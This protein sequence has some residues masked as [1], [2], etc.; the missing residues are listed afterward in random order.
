MMVSRVLLISLSSYV[1]ISISWC[2]VRSCDG[3]LHAY[4]LLYV[5]A[6]L[7]R[8]RCDKHFGKVLLTCA[9]DMPKKIEAA[10]LL[11]KSVR[12]L[13]TVVENGICNP[14]SGFETFSNIDSM[15]NCSKTL[16]FFLS[17]SKS[18]S[19]RNGHKRT[20]PLRHQ[21]K[22]FGG[23]A[24]V[25]VPPAGEGRQ[26]GRGMERVAEAPRIE[27]LWKSQAINWIY[28]ECMVIE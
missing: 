6:W 4:I 7:W 17:L 21:C 1:K 24:G 23:H 10:P 8:R 14:S 26:C 13:G 15:W 20:A 27:T 2:Y 22:F 16:S 28:H 19:I 25:W 12:S 18:P 5:Y 3:Y 11:E 9:I